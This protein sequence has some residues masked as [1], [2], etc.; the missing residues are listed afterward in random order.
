LPHKDIE[1]RRA[2][3][4]SWYAKNIEQERARG[5]VRAKVESKRRKETQENWRLAN[6]EAYK[7]QLDR[8]KVAH[9]DAQKQADRK[10]AKAHPDRVRNKHLLRTY[11]ITQEDYEKILASQDGRCAIC[12]VP[13]LELIARTGQGFHVDHN[14]KTGEIRG[15]L[16]GRCNRGLGCF[17]DSKHKLELA[18]K[19]LKEHDG[20]TDGN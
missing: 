20:S 19:Y 9:P 12:S 10:W 15:L 14:H 13:E 2:Y 1:A 5:R 7:S 6:P 3:Q 8:R 18:A 17:T 16:C 11:G 4:R